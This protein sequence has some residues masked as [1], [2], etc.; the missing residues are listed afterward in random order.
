MCIWL[1]TNVQY[2]FWN[3]VFLACKHTLV[4]GLGS[5]FPF[6]FNVQTIGCTIQVYSELVQTSLFL[7][8]TSLVCAPMKQCFSWLAMQVNCF[9]MKIQ[10]VRATIFWGVS[11]IFLW[12]SHNNCVHKYIWFEFIWLFFPCS[13]ICHFFK[14]DFLGT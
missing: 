4:K 6:V 3:W 1:K 2:Y 5:W 8:I 9:I 7:Q 12:D 10:R 13:N 14:K 11:H